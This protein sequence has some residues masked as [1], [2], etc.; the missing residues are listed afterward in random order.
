MLT[1]GTGDCY[2]FFAVSKLLFERLDIPNMDV[3]KVK[4]SEDDSEHFWS[5]VSVDGGESYYHFDATPRLGQTGPFCLITD[6]ELDAYSETHDGSH[7]RDT[8]LY[9]A[10]PEE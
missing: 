4:N 2:G 8:S 10:T 5:L 1:T 6:R 3:V 7:N 9:P